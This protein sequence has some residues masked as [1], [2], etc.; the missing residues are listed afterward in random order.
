MIGCV[1]LC[2]MS[3]ERVCYES[4]YLGVN[5]PSEHAAPAVEGVHDHLHLAM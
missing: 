5:H 1:M 3:H 2:V 4:C